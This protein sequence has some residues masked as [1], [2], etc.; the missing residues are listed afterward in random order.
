MLSFGASLN[1][2][3]WCYSAEI[4][5]LKVRGQGTALAVMNNWVW[6]SSTARFGELAFLTL[7]GIHYCHGNSNHDRAFEME[8]LFDFHGN[9]MPTSLGILSP[10]SNISLELC[11]HPSHLLPF[12]G[13]QRPLLGTDRL[14]LY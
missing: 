6:V 10:E 9:G 7:L 14:S 12:P 11:L 2:I 13:D 8:G 5:P 3:P 4:L 1:A